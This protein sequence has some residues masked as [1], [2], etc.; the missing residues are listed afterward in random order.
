MSRHVTLKRVR[1]L[2]LKRSIDVRTAGPLPLP[3]MLVVAVAC[4]GQPHHPAARPSAHAVNPLVTDGLSAHAALSV[5]Q[6]LVALD[7]SVV[8]EPQSVLV[9]DVDC[10]GR[11]D[12]AFVG[13]SSVRVA[14]GL[15]RAGGLAPDVISF[16]THG[17]AVED[18]VGSSAAELALESLDYDPRDAIGD[19][20]GFQRSK[21]CKGLNLGDGESDS[22]HIFWNQKSHHLGWW[23][24]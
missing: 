11:P 20:D 21:V 14:V 18:E 13:R 7:S 4:A 8:W 16:G 15:I 24:L 9:A 10:D 23:R 5:M 12:S 19:I 22:M 1:P 6:R 3:L 17:A 2:N